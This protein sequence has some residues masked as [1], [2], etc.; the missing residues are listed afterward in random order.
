MRSVEAAPFRILAADNGE[1]SPWA[2]CFFFDSPSHPK[3]VRFRKDCGLDEL[4]KGAKTDL[5]RALALKDWVTKSLQFGKPGPEAFSDWSATAL[6]DRVKRGEKVWC[7]QCAMVFQQA[8]MA[9]GLPARFVEVGVPDNPA[10]HFLTE[11]YLREHGKWAVVDA[12]ALAANNVYYTVDGVPQS[13]LEMHRHVVMN[14]IDKV[15]EVHPDRSVPVAEGHPGWFFYYV[16]WLLRCDIVTSTPVFVDMEHV[17]DRWGGTVEWTDDQTVPW[18]RSGKTTWWTRNVRLA[19]WNTSDP[20]VVN[21]QPTDRV[22]ITLGR[23]GQ[24]GI[25]ADLWAADPAV[26]HFQVR[27]DG[28]RWRD[29][30]AITPKAASQG[31]WS[32][33]RCGLKRDPG[34][35]EVAARIVRADGSMGPES[36]VKFAVE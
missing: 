25:F 26:D 20:A 8:C 31:H 18:E 27:I 23:D 6:L 21:W 12:T 11:V 5:D 17:F 28:R 4:V 33:R 14:T 32:S 19:A 3:L 30:P 10:C 15:V 13:A 2:E 1:V 7:G 24:G 34:D 29:L 16:R 35:R 22:R 36:L 9:V